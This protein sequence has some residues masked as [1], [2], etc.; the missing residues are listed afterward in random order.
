[1]PN[2]FEVLSIVD[3]LLVFSFSFIYF[4]GVDPFATHLDVMPFFKHIPILFF[5]LVYILYV[6][7]G[8]LSFV[9]FTRPQL[10]FNYGLVFF[11]FL[12]LIGSVFG[13]FFMI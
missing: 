13:R 10:V 3:W 2:K 5:L 7:I 8:K 11:S 12:V 4:L 1:M 9:Y 6:M